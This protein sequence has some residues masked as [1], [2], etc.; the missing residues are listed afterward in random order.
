MIY[1]NF[2]IF[3]VI[4][5]F[6]PDLTDP[7]FTLLTEAFLLS[8]FSEPAYEPGCLLWGLIVP[9]RSGL[10]DGIVNS[11]WSRSLVSFLEP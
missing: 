2:F 5:H 9:F 10:C 7:Y 4:H 1:F 8:A 3:Y 11:D 6:A